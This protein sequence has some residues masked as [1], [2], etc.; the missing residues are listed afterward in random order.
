MS[1]DLS[2]TT[3]R[4]QMAQRKIVDQNIHNL[5]KSI[6]KKDLKLQYRIG[7]RDF[8]GIVIEVNGAPGMTHVR[9]QNLMTKKMRTLGLSEIIGIVTES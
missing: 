8:F 4:R 5:A 1:S 6:F 9:V 2:L 3:L 7:A